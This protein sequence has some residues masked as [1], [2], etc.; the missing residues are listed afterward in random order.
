[1]DEFPFEVGEQLLYDAGEGTELWEVVAVYD[2]CI[3]LRSEFGAT[4]FYYGD[5]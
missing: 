1:M 2:D 3:E 4:A 5:E